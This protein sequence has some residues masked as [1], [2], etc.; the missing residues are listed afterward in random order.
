ML[1]EITKIAPLR[2]D[3]RGYAYGFSTRKNSYFI[4]INRKKGTV[5]GEHYHKGLIKSKSPEIFYLVKGKVKLLVR[6]TKSGK[7]EIYEIGENHKID[8]PS[9]VYHEF[10]ALEDFIL[11]ELNIEKTDFR[12]DSFK[13]T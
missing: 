2:E 3:D 7:E 8:I 10:F 9:N 11:L 5:S 1:V 4:V 6:D 13:L 12:K